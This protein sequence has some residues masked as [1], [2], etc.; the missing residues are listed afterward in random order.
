LST[1]RVDGSAEAELTVEVRVLEPHTPRTT[2]A[3]TWANP[4]GVDRLLCLHL[5]YGHRLSVVNA[6]ERDWPARLSTALLQQL[7]LRTRL[8]SAVA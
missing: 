4:T 2:T 7:I 1:A 5:Y 3:L 6:V 8:P